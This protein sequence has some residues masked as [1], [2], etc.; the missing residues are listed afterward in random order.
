LIYYL[1]DK[2]MQCHVLPHKNVN[3]IILFWHL[4]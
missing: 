1:S 4:Y 2:I 3:E